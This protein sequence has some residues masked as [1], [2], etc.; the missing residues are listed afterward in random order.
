MNSV[1][2]SGCRKSLVGGLFLNPV[3][4][5]A[6]VPELHTTMSVLQKHITPPK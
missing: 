5:E 1:S 3:V 4:A 2:L 6:L